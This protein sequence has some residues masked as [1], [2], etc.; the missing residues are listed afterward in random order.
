MP[1]EILFCEQEEEEEVEE[2]KIKCFSY[3]K[4]RHKSF[5]CPD[6]KMDGS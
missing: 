5:K 6:R 1:I 3:G 4:I 2:V